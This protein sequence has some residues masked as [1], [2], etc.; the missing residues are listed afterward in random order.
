MADTTTDSS[1][2]LL[3]AMAF[4]QGAGTMLA[5]RDA[6]SAALSYFNDKQLQG[7]EEN[8]W[9]EYALKT[10]EFSRAM[11]TLAAFSAARNGQLVIGPEDVRYAITAARAQSVPLLGPCGC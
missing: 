1:R 9:N 6:L 3:L 11:G 2:M 7:L 10:V 5:S 8:R 4:G